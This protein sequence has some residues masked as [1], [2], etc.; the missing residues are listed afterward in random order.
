MERFEKIIGK[1]SP[2]PAPGD[3][4][5]PPPASAQSPAQLPSP[6]A[7]PGVTAPDSI[8]GLKFIFDGGETRM[9]TSLPIAIGRAEDNTLVIQ[10]DSVSAHHAVV[11]YDERVKEV[12]LVD[13]ESLNGVMVDDLPTLKNVITD[14][15]RIALGKVRLVYRDTGYIHPA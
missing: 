7:D 9:F 13:L 15:A 5:S 14:G 11:V 8:F 10:D 12:C 4:M 2:P 6:K 3:R 1:K